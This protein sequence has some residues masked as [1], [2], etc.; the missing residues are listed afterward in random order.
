V[1]KLSQADE[2][3]LAQV[4][5]GQQAAWEQLVQRYEGRLLAF[6]RARGGGNDAED[7]VQETLIAFLGALD[8]FRGQA[9]LETYLFTILRRKVIDKHR[10]GKLSLCQ[11]HD[12]PAGDDHSAGVLRHAAAPEPTASWYVRQDERQQLQQSAL[13][14]ALDELAEGYRQ[15]LNFR[16]LKVIELL[17]YSQLRNR[18]VARLVG[19]D[20]KQVALIKHRS[21]K[22]LGRA[23][24]EALP[25]GGEGPASDALLTQVWEAQRPSCPKRSTIG[26]YLLGTLEEQWHAYIDFHLNTLGC[27][28]CL[29]NLDDLR[30]Q[31]T[32]SS[33]AAAHQRILQSTVG[34]LRKA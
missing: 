17:L 24:L 19:L 10:R 33:A 4:R 16:D 23:V 9:S 25:D 31:T 21:L 8:S 12:S 34:F 13:A 30:R 1:G 6:A 2:Y 28:Y 15:S 3:L 5:Q 11:I 32:G 26:A 27:R 22:R 7:L 20:E 29:A 14:T 18:D